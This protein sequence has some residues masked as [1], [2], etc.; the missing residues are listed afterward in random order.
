MDCPRYT[1][2]HKE[3]LEKEEVIALEKEYQGFFK[4]LQNFTGI[5]TVNLTNLWKIE[6][7]LFV[8]NDS[9]YGL[10]EWLKPGEMESLRNLSSYTLS[11][12]FDSPEEVQLTAGNWVRKVR[13]DIQGKVDGEPSL[14]DS[15]L[16]LYS[17]HDTTVAIMMNAL[18]VWDGKLPPYAT[19]FLIEL[20]SDKDGYFVEMFYRGDTFSS[21]ITPLL[22]PGCAGG[23]RCS[24]EDFE[25]LT[26]TAMEDWQKKCGLSSTVA[27]TAVGGS[28]SEWGPV[29]VVL[30]VLLG[31]SCLLT[32]GL[33]V[34]LVWVCLK[35]KS[36]RYSQLKWEANVDEE[37]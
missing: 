6:D 22:V 30:G 21:E 10:P 31:V 15:K 25:H 27:S 29:T 17:A 11:L 19:A 28:G 32:V 33:A 23:T 18:G 13:D 4:R 24:L 35:K 9:G 37:L 2:L 36:V 3:D 20:L 14:N 16:F 8:E 1:E 26:D 34:G 12:M 7:T 5:E